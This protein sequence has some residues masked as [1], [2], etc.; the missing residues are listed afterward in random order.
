MPSASGPVSFELWLLRW[1]CGKK[2]LEEAM[3]AR[4]GRML[5]N[6]KGGD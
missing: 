4:N 3:D 1:A 5:G 2:W 6:A